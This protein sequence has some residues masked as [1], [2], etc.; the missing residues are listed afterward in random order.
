[1]ADVAEPV[2][3]GDLDG[4]RR[5][6]MCGAQGARHLADAARRARAHV[7][8]AGRRLG[9]QQRQ[10][11]GLR[12]V[13][14]VDEVAQLAAVLE[15]AGRAAGGQSVGEDRG[16]AGVRGVARHPRPV[17][18]VV[19]QRGDRHPGLAREG[20]RE[21]LLVELRRRVHV[22]RVGRRVLADRLGRQTPRRSAGS[23]AR[24]GQHRD[25]LHGVAPGGPGRGS[26]TGSGPRR[27]RPCSRPA[28]AG[29]G[30]AGARARAAAR[31]CPRSLWRDVVGHVEEVD[32]QPDHRRPGGRRGRR[33]RARARPHRRRG[34]PLRSACR[35]RGRRGRRR[36]ARRRCA[37]RRSR[38][39]R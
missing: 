4:R 2:L 9:R 25:R 11:V 19:A 34:R 3:A 30:T 22:A 27:R 29:R 39:L 7:E 18:V 10:Q 21:M 23:V 8:G 6:A 26:H 32:A 15:D 12:D 31:R 14:H 13:A 36:A 1:M 37:S 20:E 33:R 16:D 24:N 28:R 5:V 38:R 35:A 17:D